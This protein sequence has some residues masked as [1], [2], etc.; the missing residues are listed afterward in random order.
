MGGQQKG[1]D[2]QATEVNYGDKNRVS[3]CG[4]GEQAVACLVGRV[5]AEGGGYYFCGR[6]LCT[7]ERTWDDQRARI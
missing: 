4:G 6:M 1:A 3:E 5:S 2:Q 7:E